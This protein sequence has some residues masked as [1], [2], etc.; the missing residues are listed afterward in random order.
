MG[1]FSKKEEDCYTQR[2][3]LLLIFKEAKQMAAIFFSVTY[4]IKL[5]K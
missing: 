1:S 2:V 3:S 5:K 4:L